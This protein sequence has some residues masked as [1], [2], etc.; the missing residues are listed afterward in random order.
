M[1]LVGNFHPNISEETNQVS[2]GTLN[3]N[4]SAIIWLSGEKPDDGSESPNDCLLHGMADFLNISCEAAIAIVN[5]LALVCFGVVVT[6]IVMIIK[7]K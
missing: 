1:R 7:R 3:L 6:V 4:T 5:C 2:G